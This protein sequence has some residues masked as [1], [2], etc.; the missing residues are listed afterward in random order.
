LPLCL[1]ISLASGYPAIAGVFTAAVGGIVG[2]AISNSS[3]TIKGPAAGLIVIA[4]GA[5]TEFRE[6][7]GPEQAYRMVLAVGVAAAGMQILFAL[8]RTGV[9][10]EFFPTSVVH[11]MLAAIGI[12]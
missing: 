4:Y 3:L 5:I 6:M 8:F 2:C 7:H 11:G 9:L 10:G 12:I 1:A